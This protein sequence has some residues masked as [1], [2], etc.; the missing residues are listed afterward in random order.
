MTNGATLFRRAYTALRTHSSS[1]MA[2]LCSR[3]TD[4][5]KKARN[6]S[7]LCLPPVNLWNFH[8]IIDSQ[9]FSKNLLIAK[10]ADRVA[11]F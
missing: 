1:V 3:L 2:V 9:H 5:K 8:K 10:D 11:D 7:Q 6:V 4:P